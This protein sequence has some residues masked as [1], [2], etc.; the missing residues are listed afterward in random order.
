MLLLLKILSYLVTLSVGCGAGFAVS[1]L[2]MS[3]RLSE[4]RK[5]NE[6]NS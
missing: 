5:K 3:K 4:K 6:P 1:A 2:M